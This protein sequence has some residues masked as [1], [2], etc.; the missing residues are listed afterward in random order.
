MLT[1]RK[2]DTCEGCADRIVKD[3]GIATYITGDPAVHEDV[4]AI[5]AATVDTYGGV[6]ILI[7]AAGVSIPGAIT[8]QSDETW[9]S[10]I[11]ANLHG[12]YYFCKEV[13]KVMID[14]GR[15]GKI[16]LVGSTRGELGYPKYT[17]YCSSKGAVHLLAKS[18]AW[19]VGQHKINVNVIAPG[20]T[21]S[22]LTQWVFDDPEGPVYKSISTRMPMGRL[23]E[24]EDF[25]GVT[26]FLASR[27]SDWVHGHVLYVDGG[28]TSG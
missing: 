16:I 2:T 1:G 18:L 17:A 24:P 15:G 11:D 14:Q 9:H 19:E 5:V 4:K 28:Y 13:V 21:R 25:E 23:G 8:E 22:P 20:T 3:G 26:L 27:A 12:T 7:T 6:D 10:V